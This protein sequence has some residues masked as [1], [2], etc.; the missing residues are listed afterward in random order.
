MR[1]VIDLCGKWELVYSNERPE[2]TSEIPCFD[3][4]YTTDAVPGWWEDMIPSLQMAPY[5]MNVKFNPEFR[6]LRYPMTGSVPDMVLETIVGCFWYR[7][8][9]YISEDH[10]DK[11]IVFKCGGVQNRGLL[12]VNGIFAGEHC[13]YS[14]SFEFDITD[15]IKLG[16][17]NEFIF[18]VSNHEQYSELGEPISGVTSRAANRY[19][20]GV[21]GR[22]DLEIRNK[23]AISDMYIS[24]YDKETD[25]F[26]VY[27]EITGSKGYDILW[28]IYD[29]SNIVRSG[30]SNDC[31]FAIKRE[32]LE[33]WSDKSPKLYRL[34]LNVR[35]N[36]E[37]IDTKIQNIGIRKL[38]VHGYHLRLNGEP[39]YLRG[40][41]EHGYFARTV[42]P[43]PDIKYY[44]KLI[45][46]DQE[47]GFNFV[48]FHTWIPTEEYMQ[49]A[50]E[51]G[52]LLHVESP[53]NTTE[54]E[55][56]DIMK[57]VRRHP[58]VVICCCGNELC[59]DD[60]FMDHI[61]RC[62]A[63]SHALA[64]DLLFAP[65]S[66]M[67][68]VEYQWH[69]SNLEPDPAYVPFKH[70]P[71]RMKRVIACSDIFESSGRHNFAYESI[72]GDPDLVDSWA[73]FYVR[74][75]ITHEICIHGTYVDL[76]LEW[77]Y[78]GTRIGESEVFSSPRKLIYEA[79]IQ[80]RAPT[81]YINSCKWQ[82]ILRKHSFENARRCK[83]LCGLDC[84]GDI[85]HHWHTF[86]YRVGIMNEFYEMK[87]GETAAN[88]RRYNG[89]SVILNDLNTNHI[90]SENDIIKI[91]F[92]ISLYG[93]RDLKDSK[94]ELRFESMNR[95]ILSRKSFTVNAPNG[96]VSEIALLEMP[97]PK[98][99]KPTCIRVCAR[100]SED[101]YEIDNE[102]DI[103]VF[104]EVE[105]ACEDGILCVNDLD[106]DTL[107]K[108]EAGADVL[109]IGSGPFA[110]NPLS[111]QISLAGR[112]AGNLATVIDHHP[113][114]ETFEHEGFC[115]WQF[116]NLMNNAAVLYYRP[117]TTVPFDPIIDVASS[118]KWVR[119]QSALAEFRVGKGRL[120]ISTFD[121]SK[122]DVTA[123]WWKHNLVSY[124][125]GKSFL[126]KNSVTVSQLKTMYSDDALQRA[127]E[128]ENLSANANDITMKN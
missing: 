46:T 14:T 80:D 84:L 126:P 73:E 71:A 123:R 13:G 28:N 12:W 86:G 64:P 91:K 30:I 32:N 54:A 55:W 107:S 7:R 35:I 116:F 40:I 104:P 23:I 59:I 2:I 25:T 117:G 56:I 67:R 118:Y 119:K 88:V 125:K 8:N 24:G 102:W 3:K 108:L 6:T 65:M 81:Y 34:E 103:W 98:I 70:N 49:A 66:A 128:N 87:P 43:D 60:V 18:A 72:K 121:L 50:D 42:H 16:E 94:L 38:L 99:D 93:G 96:A 120:L 100:I 41:C 33:F 52:M 74:P 110:S 19:T 109:L 78:D 89:E 37:I 115:G 17:L 53:N 44:Y 69:D 58:S 11:A 4:S 48:R 47:L 9:V 31:E 92:F 1:N 22:I 36:G 90:F 114:T 68:G 21:T 95:R 51:L 45:K 15:Y 106:N 62:S 39:V 83:T 79:G 122:N 101:I 20:G 113:L 85:D 124:M 27:S 26:T 75:R 29:G 105:P 97:A 10:F 63:I 82:S 76:G 61:E 127:V 57:F 112:T 77:R 111:F 5:W